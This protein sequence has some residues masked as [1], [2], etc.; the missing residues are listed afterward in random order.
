MDEEAISE[1][2]ALLLKAVQRLS[3]FYAQAMISAGFSEEDVMDVQD[4]VM[5][6]QLEDIV[7]GYIPE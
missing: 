4:R 5:I 2:Q 3:G 7:L 6:F 1:T